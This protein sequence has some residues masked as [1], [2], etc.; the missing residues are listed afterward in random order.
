MELVTIL[1]V[2]PKTCRLVVVVVASVTIGV[3]EKIRPSEFKKRRH[4]SV[5]PTIADIAPQTLV[6]AGGTLVLVTG[7]THQRRQGSPRIISQFV[8]VPWNGIGCCRHIQEGNGECVGILVATLFLRTPRTIHEIGGL[9]FLAK[10]RGGQV[11]PI[12][13]LL[14]RHLHGVKFGGFQR[15]DGMMRVNQIRHTVWTQHKGQP[16]G[17][18][19]HA[20]LGLWACLVIF[21]AFALDGT[22]PHGL[23]RRVQHI[24]YLV[25]RNPAHAAVGHLVQMGQI[26]LVMAAIGGGGGVVVAITAHFFTLSYPLVGCWHGWMMMSTSRSI[27]FLSSTVSSDD[28]S[29]LTC[30]DT[31]RFRLSVNRPS[32]HLLTCT[33][34][35]TSSRKDPHTSSVRIR[36][37]QHNFHC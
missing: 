11:T 18:V 9:H 34:A 8:N 36:S 7:F 22:A 3:V 6:V 35:I 21:F 33:H 28:A 23:L 25:P 19:V 37:C 20:L 27:F 12:A 26:A 13:H 30:Q 29:L 5:G 4:A 16:T 15:T 14:Q 31:F 10:G 17:R 24:T 1:C 32:D 2:V